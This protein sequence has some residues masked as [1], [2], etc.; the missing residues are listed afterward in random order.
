MADSDRQEADPR[1]VGHLDPGADEGGLA[2]GRVAPRTIID[3]STDGGRT[4]L[5]MGDPAEF[6]HPDAIPAATVMIV[7]DRPGSGAETLMLKRDAG[8][9][10]AGGMWVFPGGRIDDADL[11][12]GAP[13]GPRGI[14]LE[15]AARRA[16][17]RETR[18]EAGLVIE[19]EHLVRW[20]HWTAPA[21]TSR[22]FTTAFYMTVLDDRGLVHID[23]HEIR[24]FQWMTPQE[25]LEGHA[26]GEL[27]LTPPTFITLTQMLSSRTTAELVDSTAERPMEHFA[28]R[29]VIRDDTMIATYHGDAGYVS[30][31]IDT[32]GPRHRLTLG[33]P[34]FYERTF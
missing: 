4:I 9:T 16:A 11:S 5:G 15:R 20:S 29:F 3:E 34:W 21:Q 23:D 6:W 28:T 7:R 24:E 22:R 10:F 1:A 27:G 2:G 14:L 31:D 32:P 33:S 12:D 8:L 17:Q 19:M 13:T 18:E 30:G 25:V 26:E